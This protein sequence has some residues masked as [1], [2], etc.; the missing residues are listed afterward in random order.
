MGNAMSGSSLVDPCF[1]PPATWLYVTC[2]FV[3]TDID[4]SPQP[5]CGPSLVRVLRLVF[6]DANIRDWPIYN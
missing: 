2:V 5:F 1:P 4:V 6:G 3:S